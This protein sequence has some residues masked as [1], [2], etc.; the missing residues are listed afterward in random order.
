LEDSSHQVFKQ[1]FDIAQLFGMMEDYQVVKYT[2]VSVVKKEAMYKSIKNAPKVVL[3][4]ALQTA[5]DI[6][7][8]DFRR[9][10]LSDEYELLI[11][12]GISKMT[13]DLINGKDF[14]IS[15][16]KLAAG[17]AAYLVVNILM[18]QDECFPFKKSKEIIAELKNNRFKGKLGILDR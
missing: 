15:E 9:E 14:S 6:C 1:L 10:K 8:F 12:G 7:T 17:K 13:N 18:N 2:Y 16:A 5:F 4:D 11:R 3:L